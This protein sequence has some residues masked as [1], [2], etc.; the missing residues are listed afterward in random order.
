VVE[1]G[2][3]GHGWEYTLC[4]KLELVRLLGGIKLGV[5]KPCFFVALPGQKTERS[6][7]GC[8]S[9]LS[10]LLSRWLL[11]ITRGRLDLWE[12]EKAVQRID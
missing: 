1:G 7:L 9:S 8:G 12:V 2:G 11:F 5:L 3:N 6:D 4:V 10:L